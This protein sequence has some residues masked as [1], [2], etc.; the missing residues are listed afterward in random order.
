MKRT[1]AAASAAPDDAALLQEIT[2]AVRSCVSAALKR[3]LKR[4]REKLSKERRDAVARKAAAKIV[5]AEL[6]KHSEASADAPANFPPRFHLSD[7]K[8][9]KIAKLV[10]GYVKAAAAESSGR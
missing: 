1:A 3:L 5:E 8:Q 2:A 4:G 9:K 10:E 7:S 6:R